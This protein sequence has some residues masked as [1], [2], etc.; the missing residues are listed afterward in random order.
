MEVVTLEEDYV[1]GRLRTRVLRDPEPGTRIYKH[2]IRNL[3][4][5]VLTVKISGPD[6]DD[7]FY[8]IPVGGFL[9][10]ESGAPEQF[11][12]REDSE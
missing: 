3:G 6:D 9:V 8:D 5:D 10:M 1:N 2:R 11:E 7:N 4:G 12:I